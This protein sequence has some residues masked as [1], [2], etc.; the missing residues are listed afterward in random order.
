MKRRTWAKC[1]GWA[2]L[3]AALG[4]A[5]GLGGCARILGPRTVEISREELL[6]KLSKQ[7]P[8]TKR[9]MNVL[10]VSA[11]APRL[12]LLPE[13]NRVAAAIDLQ[14]TNVLLGQAYEGRI[15]LSFGLR[16][17][18]KDL[19]I[20]LAEVK[21][22]TVQVEGLPE[23]L[24]RQL[25]SLGAWVAEERLQDFPVYRFHPDDLR[26]ADR[27]GYVVGGIQVTSTG[28]AI[29]VVPRP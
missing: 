9:V 26:S 11:T 20:R 6:A 23:V 18:P 24:Q 4:L 8:T 17:E 15:A 5:A 25:T 21:V 1:L 16:Y 22:V 2:S 27:L 10:D 29:S 12:T 7:F 14:A 3:S 13:R 28:L 19:S